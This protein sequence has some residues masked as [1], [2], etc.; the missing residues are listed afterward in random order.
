MP[1]VDDL[2]RDCPTCGAKPGFQ[3]QKLDGSG[4]RR[5]GSHLARATMP[6]DEEIAAEVVEIPAR[7]PGPRPWTGDEAR[8]TVRITGADQVDTWQMMCA[9]RGMRPHELAREIVIE[10]IRAAQENHEIQAAVLAARRNKAGL[11]LVFGGAGSR[12][13]RHELLRIADGDQDAST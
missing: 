9:F 8:T 6:T 11:R 7:R 12:A 3:C 1:D 10:A 2:D 13:G 5:S 4:A